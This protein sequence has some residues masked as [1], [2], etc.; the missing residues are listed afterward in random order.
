MTPAALSTGTCDNNPVGRVR[1][2][3]PNRNYPGFWGGPGASTNWRSDTFRGDAPGGEPEVD[4]IRKLVSSRQVT[5]LI[6]NHTYSNLVLRPPSLASTGFSPDELQYRALGA[7]FAEHND[8]ANI[9]SFGL[10]DTSGSTEDWSYWNTGGFGFTFEIGTEGFHPAYE[11][12]VVAE[13]M[14]LAPAAGAGK[15]GN[16]EAYYDAAEAARKTRAALDDHRQ[17][18]GEH[19]PDDPQVLRRHDL[20]GHPARRHRRRP[21]PLHRR[22]HVLA[23]GQGRVV[24]VGGQPVDPAARRRSLRP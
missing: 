19:D 15:G 8:Y 4:N 20:P 17:G 9:P 21:D 14:G 23:R 22:P 24:L 10:Y 2:T 5:T 1:G 13:Y 12:G 7:Q 11:T 3:D 6:T 16:R 18:A